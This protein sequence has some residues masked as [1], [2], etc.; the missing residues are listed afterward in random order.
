ML[1]L[2]IKPIFFVARPENLEYKIGLIVV[3]TFSKF[4]SVMMLKNKTPDVILP[5]MEKAFKTLG[6]MPQ[7]LYSDSEGSFLSKELNEFYKKHNIK[8]IITRGH[9]G[10]VE[11]FVRTLKNMFFKRWKHE[12]DKTLYEIIHEVL[13]TL[14][15]IRKSSA[16][17]LTPA[18][19]RKPENWIKVWRDEERL[20]GNILQ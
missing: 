13:V 4:C 14:N 15:Y 8:H 11:R 1:I 17:G 7:I 19:A 5:A 10:V 6:G 2:N 9:A 18:E 20:H 16:T 3:D 12:P